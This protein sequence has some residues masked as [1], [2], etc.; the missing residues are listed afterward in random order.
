VYSN[1]WIGHRRERYPSQPS[2]RVRPER[3]MCAPATAV[4]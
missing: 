1:R 4:V 3:L 2:K